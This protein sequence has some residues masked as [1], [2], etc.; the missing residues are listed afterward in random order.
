MSS[1]D[2]NVVFSMQMDGPPAPLEQSIPVGA[3]RPPLP[4]L[5]P[6]PPLPPPSLRLPPLLALSL[7]GLP[8]LPPLRW[9]V[10][11]LEPQAADIARM[12]VA[13]TAITIRRIE[14]VLMDEPARAFG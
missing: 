7:L 2:E 3:A 11:A 10:P 8:A 5:P 4:V 1:P 13:P 6:P 14:L 12:L 9:T